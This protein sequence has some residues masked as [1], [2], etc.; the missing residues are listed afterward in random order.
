[1]PL[2]LDT[3]DQLLVATVQKAISEA[4]AGAHMP[5]AV[6]RRISVLATAVWY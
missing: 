6:A 2:N 4:I 3:H 1:M 5:V